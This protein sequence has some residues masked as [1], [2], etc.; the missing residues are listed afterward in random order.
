MK[1]ASG[2][3][4]TIE[5]PNPITLETIN[6]FVVATPSSTLND[7]VLEQTGMFAGLME[8]V[9]GWSMWLPWLALLIGI[10]VAIYFIFVRSR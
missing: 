5:T 4:P 8:K 1:I 9:S 3:Q 7:A 6:E 10:I 2:G